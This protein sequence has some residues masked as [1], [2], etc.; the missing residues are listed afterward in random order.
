MLTPGR[1]FDGDLTIA[2]PADDDFMTFRLRGG[3]VNA[4]PLVRIPR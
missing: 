4:A 1:E 2:G 3:A